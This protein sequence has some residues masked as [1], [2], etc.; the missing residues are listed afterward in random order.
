MQLTDFM[1]AEKGYK[2]CFIECS[3]KL[4]INLNLMIYFEKN[5]N[6]NHKIKKLIDLDSAE[7]EK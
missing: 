1:L 2:I 4:C 3:S 6:N 7:S 5:T